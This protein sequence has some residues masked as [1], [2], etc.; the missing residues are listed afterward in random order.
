MCEV[1]ELVQWHAGGLVLAG[2][3]LHTA[4]G[5]LVNVLVLGVDGEAEVPVLEGDGV[6]LGRETSSLGYG[7]A[8]VVLAVTL[9]Q[10][11]P[12]LTGVSLLGV[13][14]VRL[15]SFDAF[16]PECRLIAHTLVCFPSLLPASLVDAVGYFSQERLRVSPLGE[17]IVEPVWFLAGTPLT[18]GGAAV[19]EC[20]RFVVGGGLLAGQLADGSAGGRVRKYR[21]DDGG[22][23][24]PIVV[25][26]YRSLFGKMA[27]TKPLTVGATCTGG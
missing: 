8:G 22:E 5:E 19:E 24:V 26:G 12:V 23:H 9:C 7:Q 27:S 11:P 3:Q 20:H 18:D 17:Q 14:T 21:G 2:H 6:S 16:S 13:L 25:H 1:L 10:G 15:C 4:D